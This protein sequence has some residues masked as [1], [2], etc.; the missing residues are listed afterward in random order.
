VVKWWIDAVFAVHQDMKSHTGGAMSLA[1][2]VYGTSTREKLNA[3]SSTEGGLVGLSDVLPQVLWTRHFLTDQEYD[4]KDSIVYQ[5]NQSAIL[6]EKNGRASSSKG[7]RHINIRYFFVADRIGAGELRISY[8]SKDEMLANFF[9]KPLQGSLF[10]KCQ[11][12]VMNYD[13]SEADLV[14]RSVLENE[15]T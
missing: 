1:K 4:V 11:D 15:A 10:Q 7:T 9:T 2:G 3:R 13:S 6:L 5:D 12:Q 14:H 8:C